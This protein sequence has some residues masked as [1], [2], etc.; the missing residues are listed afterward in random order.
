MTGAASSDLQMTGT[1]RPG[2]NH[3]DAYHQYL[4]RH[5]PPGCDRA[6]DVGCGA[7]LLARRLAKRVR[8]VDAIDRAATGRRR[9][10]IT[11][12]TWSRSPRT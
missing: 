8:S 1:A 5:V 9:R 3:N 7:G 11:R 10:P 6:L 12:A 2:F 4:L